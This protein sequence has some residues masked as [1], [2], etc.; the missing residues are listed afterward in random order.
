M[1]IHIH[2]HSI[3]KACSSRGSR[4]RK[5]RASVGREGDDTVGDPRRAQSYQLTLFELVISLNLDNQLYIERFEPTVSQSTV[6]SPPHLSQ[7]R[8]L[9]S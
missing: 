8:T 1:Y 7:D 6:S 5:T 2:I 3:G 4:P 9:E